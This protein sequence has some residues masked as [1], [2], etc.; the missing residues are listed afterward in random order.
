[1]AA[2]GVHL[3]PVRFGL[4]LPWI[5]VD[6]FSSSAMSVRSA[7]PRLPRPG[8]PVPLNAR[9][10]RKE[11]QTQG[12]RGGGAPRQGRVLCGEIG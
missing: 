12:D 4:G 2:V 1:M 3:W 7:A 10:Y 6:G 9:L 8:S 11:Q 5:G